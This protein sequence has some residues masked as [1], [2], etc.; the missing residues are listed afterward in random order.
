MSAKSY[1]ASERRGI[2]AIAVI[3]LIIIG[4]GIGFSFFEKSNMQNDAEVVELKEAVDT[5]SNKKIP[6][7]KSQK[8]KQGGSTKKAIKKA[9][10]K[11]SPKQFRRRS[12]LDEPV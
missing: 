4:A 3:A 10:S 1:T 8:R 11:K 12:P 5:L 2:I 9:K 7:V 6:E